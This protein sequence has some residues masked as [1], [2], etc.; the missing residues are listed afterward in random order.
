MNAIP[1]LNYEDAHAAPACSEGTLTTPDG[2]CR[3][4]SGCAPGHDGRFQDE[5][6]V[7]RGIRS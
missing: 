3:S 6:G 2:T 7:L 5:P 4:S 1:F